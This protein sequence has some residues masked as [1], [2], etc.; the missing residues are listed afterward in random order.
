MRQISQ[1]E[2]DLLTSISNRCGVD[3]SSRGLSPSVNVN[4]MDDGGMG[5]LL[6]I[7][8]QSSK[9]KRVY[10]RTIMEGEFYDLDGSVVSLAVNVDSEDRLLEMD[11]WKTDF[12]PL[13]KVP[14]TNIPFRFRIPDMSK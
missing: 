11:V 5:S 3:L 6:F 1:D 9:N 8:N 12:S 14:P 13:I 10:G 4:P 7:L 2:Y